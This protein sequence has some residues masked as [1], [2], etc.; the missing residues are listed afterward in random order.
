MQEAEQRLRTEISEASFDSQKDVVVHEAV[1][2]SSLTY[3]M[4]SESYGFSDD[5]EFTGY[6]Q[7]VSRSGQG[8]RSAADTGDFS[9]FEL[10]L[11]RLS[12]A[13]QACHREYKSN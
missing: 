1:I 9:E 10:N 6:A 4:T 13:C 12:T 5:P 11:S 8:I 3:A 7:K 2:L